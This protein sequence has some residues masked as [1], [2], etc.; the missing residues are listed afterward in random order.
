MGL[1]RLRRRVSQ[2]VGDRC[3]AGGGER[4]LSC[5]ETGSDREII[6]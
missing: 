4:R 6:D 3:R 2:K 5:T 1:R